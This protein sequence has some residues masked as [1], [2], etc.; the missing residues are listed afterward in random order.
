MISSSL[1]HDLLWR[2][3]DVQA[4]NRAEM[5]QQKLEF[6]Q[7]IELVFN[8]KYSDKKV[9]LIFFIRYGSSFVK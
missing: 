8:C 5:I 6:K 3:F 9:Y 4:C 7:T 2:T 1:I